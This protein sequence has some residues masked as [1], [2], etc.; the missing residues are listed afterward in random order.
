MLPWEPSP[1]WRRQLS[2]AGNGLEVV[3]HKIEMY[4]EDKQDDIPD[5]IW[6]RTTVLFTKDTFPSKEKAPK[7]K[8]VQLLSAGCNQILNRPIF[9]D[10][11]TSFCTA[12]GV[13]PP[14]IA[15]WVYSTFL[16]FQHHCELSTS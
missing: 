4:E 3:S 6:A 9:T 8:Y 1:E 10:T 16:A 12:N 7:L 13:H 11:E 14:Q 15:E 2:E 5:E